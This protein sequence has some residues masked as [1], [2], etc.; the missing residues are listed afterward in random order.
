MLNFIRQKELKNALR[1]IPFDGLKPTFMHH[2][3][4]EDSNYL[5]DISRIDSIFYMGCIFKALQFVVA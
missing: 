5:Q 3:R 1:R 2:R 4:S